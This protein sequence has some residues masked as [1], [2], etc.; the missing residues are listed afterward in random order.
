[1]AALRL[2]WEPISLDTSLWPASRPRASW[3]MGT[4]A[5]LCRPCSMYVHKCWSVG[6]PP[7]IDNNLWP[8]SRS[9]TLGT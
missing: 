2:S 6:V 4:T 7:G 5:N 1:M 8:A 3:D 9:R